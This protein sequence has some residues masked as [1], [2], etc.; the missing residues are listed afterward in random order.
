MHFSPMSW[1]CNRTCNGTGWFCLRAKRYRTIPELLN[2]M[3]S[4]SGSFIE[5]C[6]TTVLIPIISTYFHIKIS[7]YSLDLITF[8]MAAVT[9]S[10]CLHCMSLFIATIHSLPFIPPFPLIC[11]WLSQSWNNSVKKK[12]I[13]LWHNISAEQYRFHLGYYFRH[14]TK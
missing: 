8:I 6:S 11:F 5:T 9:R 13:T 12:S 1:P 14:A 10:T 2:F 7:K 4:D 3:L